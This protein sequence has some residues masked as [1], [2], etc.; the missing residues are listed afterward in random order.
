MLAAASVLT[1][2]GGAW[3]PPWSPQR[4]GC[5]APGQSL[6]EPKPS[7]R[8]WSIQSR[9]RCIARRPRLCSIKPIRISRTPNA[10]NPMSHDS[11]APRS[12]RTW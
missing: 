5:I 10:R 4:S 8:D 7:D 2:I 9:L 1:V 11:G 3:F 6:I 12:S